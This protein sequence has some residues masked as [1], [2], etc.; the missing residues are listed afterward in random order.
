[1]VEK[2]PRRLERQAAMS[3]AEMVDDLPKHCS[4]GIKRNAK[5]HTTSP[6]TNS[7]IGTTRRRA[8]VRA[9]VAGGS[10]PPGA[11]QLIVSSGK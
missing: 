9:E 10:E 4:V 11:N 7:E 6:N 1:V 2:E 8:P 5:G 3:L